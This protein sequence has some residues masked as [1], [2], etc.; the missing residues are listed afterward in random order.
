MTLERARRV[1]I[2]LGVVAVFAAGVATGILYERGGAEPR[3]ERP[4]GDHSVHGDP[5]ARHLEQFRRRLELTDEQ[6][7]RVKDVLGGVHQAAMDLS[8][9][10]RTKFAAVR[11][12]AWEDIRA[13]LRQDQLPEFEKLVE[14]LERVHA[15]H[16]DHSDRAGRD[17]GSHGRGQ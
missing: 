14:E 16:G 3:A 17:H 6:S 10:F 15:A 8:G 9:E 2:P 1:W 13:T 12:R 4:L 11:T 7:R 5:A